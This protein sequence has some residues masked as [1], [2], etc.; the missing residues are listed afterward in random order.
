MGRVHA[1]GFSSLF[2]LGR[3][4]GRGPLLLRPGT[5]GHSLLVDPGLR[6][7]HSWPVL[8]AA[9]VP[10]LCPVST[11]P[12]RG[13][14][15]A[16]GASLGEG[17]QARRRVGAASGPGPG[18]CVCGRALGSLCPVWGDGGYRAGAS[19]GSSSAA[20]QKP[21]PERAPN[22]PR[23]TWAPVVCAPPTV[24]RG[25]PRS[26]GLGGL[27]SALAASSPG[28][29]RPGPW[30]GGAVLSGARSLTHPASWASS[31]QPGRQQPV[32]G[33]DSCGP[34]AVTSAAWASGSLRRPHPPP[35]P[36]RGLQ[37]AAA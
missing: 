17:G 24:P 6:E 5:R 34:R 37:D 3:P 35:L 14:V 36:H 27:G 23:A 4:F 11:H 10:G 32:A 30:W 12:P 20:S 16:E 31:A 7:P 28:A 13:P 8:P 33:E 19:R 15:S 22:K 9:S 2:K 29:P 1:Y 26:H 18:V 25:G 21:I